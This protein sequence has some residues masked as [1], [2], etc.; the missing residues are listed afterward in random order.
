MSLRKSLT[1]TPALLAANRASAGKLPEPRTPEGESRVAL[2]ALRQGV[3]APDFLS[4]LGKSTFA[5]EEDKQQA[6]WSSPG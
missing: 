5:L 1:R 3:H 4:A 2:G 6:N